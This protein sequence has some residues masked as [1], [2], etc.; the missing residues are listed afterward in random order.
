VSDHVV[1][2]AELRRKV[3]DV[4]GKEPDVREAE[5]GDIGLPALDLNRRKID[6]DEFRTGQRRRDR[7]QVAARR[8]ADLEH[9]A[10]VDRRRLHPEQRTDRRQAVRMR[11]WEGETLVRKVIVALLQRP[12]DAH[13]C[14]LGAARLPSE[15]EQFAPWDG[16]AALMDAPV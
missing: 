14:T 10:P 7:D 4:H 8:A 12:C 9:A 2:A 11:L 5:L 15:R 3:A 16:P 1:E 13:G 6:P